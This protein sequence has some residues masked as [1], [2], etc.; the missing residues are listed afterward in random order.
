[1]E[2]IEEEARE[3]MRQLRETVWALHN[4]AVTLGAFRDRLDADIASRLRGRPAPE[5]TVTLD[6]D[7]GHVLSPLQALHLYRVA[8]EAVTNSLKH[9]DAAVLRVVIRQRHGEIAVEVS[10]DGTFQEASGDGEPATLSG[11]GMGSMQARAK[12]LGGHFELDTASGTTVR[13][14]VPADPPGRG[15][16]VSLPCS[17][18]RRGGRARVLLGSG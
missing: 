3:T 10:D 5:A 4:E 1:M 9:A 17:R 14:T 16:A 7:P 2:R 13:I 12:A 6:G 15:E 11:F 18:E 8:R